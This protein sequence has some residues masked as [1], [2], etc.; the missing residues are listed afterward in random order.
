MH[1]WS[2]RYQFDPED[3]ETP[4]CEGN[5]TELDVLSMLSIS[6]PPALQNNRPCTVIIHHRQDTRLVVHL[7]PTGQ[8]DGTKTSNDA[9]Q[10]KK[11]SIL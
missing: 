6:L 4:V 7:F 8:S 5:L 9:M 3:S 11:R 1:S 2:I 10:K